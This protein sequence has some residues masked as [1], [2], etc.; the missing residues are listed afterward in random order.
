LISKNEMCFKCARNLT[1]T[2]NAMVTI[3]IFLDKRKI[4]KEETYP[5]NFRIY[6]W[7]KSATRSTKTYLKEDQW[8]HRFR[9]LQSLENIMIGTRVLRLHFPLP[10][11]FMR[12]NTK[13]KTQES[14]LH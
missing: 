1:I 3:K 12:L 10:L 11:N 13:N 8:D 5:L 2:T 7:G 4:T 14:Y 9:N 6:Y